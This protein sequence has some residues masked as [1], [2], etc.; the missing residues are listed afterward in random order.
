T[1]VYHKNQ[2]GIIVDNNVTISNSNLDNLNNG[3]GDYSNT[4]FTI[5]RSGGP[6]SNDVFSFANMPDVTIVNNNLFSNGYI[7]ANYTNINGQLQI[8]FINEGLIPNKPL[9]NEIIQAIKYQNTSIT[10]PTQ[11]SLAYSFDNAS[12]G[13]NATNLIASINIII[14]P[15]EIIMPV[16]TSVNPFIINHDPVLIA[17]GIVI[18]DQNGLDSLN[19]NLGDYNGAKL[20]IMRSG[21]ISDVHDVFYFG[22]I[23]GVTVDSLNNQ[24]LYNGHPIANFTNSSGKLELDFVSTSSTKVTTALVNSIVNAIEYSNTSI[25]PPT[26]V[27]LNYLFSDGGVLNA[28]QTAS[29]NITINI[30]P[31]NAPPTLSIPANLATTENH[32]IC[33]TGNNIIIAADDATAG[34]EQL[35]LSVTNGTLNFNPNTQVNVIAGS[36]GTN[37]ITIIGTIAQLNTALNSL[38]YTPKLNATS[39]DTLVINLNDQ[40]NY[41]SGGVL[42][43][44][45]NIPITI[46]ASVINTDQPAINSLDL[47]S[48]NIYHKNQAA[49][50]I[51]NNVTITNSNLDL[52]NNGLG[53]YSNTQFTIGR[54]SGA[55]SHDVFSFASMPDVT[56]SSNNLLA[57]GLIIA[58]FTNTNGQLQIQFINNGLIPSQ[59]LVN[60]IIQAIKYQNTSS[61]LPT[62]VSLAY[63]FDNATGGANATNL[64]ASI[65]IIID[66][67]Q[68]IMPDET[69][70]FISN[71]DPVLIASSIVIADLNGLDS[72]NNNLGNYHGSKLTIMRTGGQPNLEDMFYFGSIP[73]VSV[74]S[75]NSTLLYNADPIANF[76]SNNGK[77]ELDFISTA[78]TKITTALVNSIVNAI[79]Y[80]NISV[81]PP[82]NVT[83]NY[84]FSDGG[85]LNTEQTASANITVNI[86]TTVDPVA[87]V[88]IDSLAD[89]SITT[90]TVSTPITDHIVTAVY[91]IMDHDSNNMDLAYITQDHINNQYNLNLA[92]S[93]NDGVLHVNVAPIDTFDS[94]S[95][96]NVNSI[97]MVDINQDHNLDLLV[98]TGQAIN[99]YQNEGS[100]QFTS[101]IIQTAY[102]A[103]GVATGDLFNNGLI[104]LVTIDQNQAIM[105]MFANT[106]DNQTF[107]STIIAN[108]PE[109]A[110]LKNIFVTDLNHDGNLDVLVTSNAPLSTTNIVEYLNN[111]N[112]EFAKY[113]DPSL[114]NNN[115]DQLLSVTNSITD[116]SSTNLTTENDWLSNLLVHNKVIGTTSNDVL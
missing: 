101:H 75:L 76:I 102:Q 8:Q 116:K 33:F 22:N 29:A 112:G 69:A 27:T 2:A 39:N 115:I 70:N 97:Q 41:G 109:L 24:L 25:L 20:T 51:D 50:V 114:N 54:T 58:N 67:P 38:I 4:Q 72:L 74:D 86:Q 40:G 105:R 93:N 62:Q 28:E 89:N 106:G 7:I 94:N 1:N 3:L 14:D 104:D 71:H 95:N 103:A 66:P 80:S 108:D 68:I 91:G 81:E 9:V 64:I 15:P 85:V 42:S 31:V 98:N 78:N 35:S 6:N 57:E 100:G 21:G 61:T 87:K 48:T 65:N 44:T 37:A 45:K 11:V 52:L 63:N 32:S 107:T 83:L 73:G 77:L 17:S 26:Q 13:A 16:A 110:F 99:W 59:V 92:I 43:I 36:N 55:N 34:V 47:Q 46:T 60:E 82:S 19:N 79:E 10:P 53:D 5:K 111:G 12:G 18:T 88:L 49:I 30:D 90:F 96:I 84:L 56:V 113:I 23:I